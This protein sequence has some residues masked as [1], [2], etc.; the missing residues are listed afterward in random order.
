M[1]KIELRAYTVGIAAFMILIAIMIIPNNTPELP[2]TSDV[3][4]TYKH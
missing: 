4:C 2:D 3:S 1:K